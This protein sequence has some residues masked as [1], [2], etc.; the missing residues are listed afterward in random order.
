MFEQRRLT[1]SPNALSCRAQPII[2]HRVQSK[3]SQSPRSAHRESLPTA[4]ML[5]GRREA[6]NKTTASPT[7]S[8]RRGRAAWKTIWTMPW[9]RNTKESAHSLRITKVCEFAMEAEHRPEGQAALLNYIFWPHI[10]LPNLVLPKWFFRNFG[11][12]K[13][14]AEP[15]TN[16]WVSCHSVS[17]L[18][19]PMHF[20][21]I[22]QRVSFCVAVFKNFLNPKPL[23]QISDFQNVFFQFWIL[24]Q[25]FPNHGPMIELPVLAYTTKP[26]GFCRIGQII[27]FYV[28]YIIICLSPKPI[29]Q[30]W[31]F[32]NMFF[33]ILSPRNNTFPLK[34]IIEFPVFA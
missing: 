14:L 8:R 29:F 22:K 34:P 32:Q 16:T 18:L 30:I 13:I 12:R 20:C 6:V 24:D 7:P 31:D 11:T 9:M 17:K 28:D 10:D 25:S 19:K 1:S 4:P 23:F 27:S 33:T 2:S 26:Y 5:A 3:R 21:I 15:Q